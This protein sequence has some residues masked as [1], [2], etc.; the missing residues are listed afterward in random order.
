MNSRTSPKHSLL[1]LHKWLLVL[2]GL[3][4]IFLIL[5]NSYRQPTEKTTVPQIS[6]S[7]IPVLLS[8]TSSPSATPSPLITKTATPLI[9]K[10]NC[11]IFNL[12]NGPVSVKINLKSES[13]NVLGKTVVRIKPSGQCPNESPTQEHWLESSELTWTS[14]GVNPGRYLLEAA[15]GNYQGV[16][17]R[18]VDLVQGGYELT[19]SLP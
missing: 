2:V 14:S 13:G 19:I 11:S 16:V 4:S 8:P 17:S 5:R 9:K 12:S 15:N 6:P 18:R 3:L 1:P 7:V 10:N